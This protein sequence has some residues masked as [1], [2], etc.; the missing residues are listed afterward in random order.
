MLD[1]AEPGVL[2]EEMPTCLDIASSSSHASEL[3]PGPGP[4]RHFAVPLAWLRLPW[5]VASQQTGKGLGLLL[6]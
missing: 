6:G 5:F 3:A 4:G 2:A 1:A